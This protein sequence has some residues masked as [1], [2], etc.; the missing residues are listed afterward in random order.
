MQSA[1]KTVFAAATM[2]LF[3][4]LL[5]LPANGAVA[6]SATCYGS[7]WAL[8]VQAPTPGEVV[9]ASSLAIQVH[10]INY[11]LNARYAGTPDLPGIG[12]YHE[13]LDNYVPGMG[14]QPMPGVGAGIVDLAPTTNPTHDQ[15]SMT[16]VSNTSMP[17]A[18]PVNG[19]TNLPWPGA[20]YVTPGLHYLTLVPACNDHTPDWAAAVNIPFTYAGPYIPE[21][22]YAG[23]D[24]SPTLG[25]VSPA[26]GTGLNGTSFDMTVNV[27]NFLLCGPCYAKALESNVGHWHMFALPGQNAMPGDVMPGVFSS[28]SAMFMAMQPHMVSM[29]P[30][31]LTQQGY[32][33]GLASSPGWYTFYAVLVANNHMPF[34]VPVMMN[35]MQIG[36]MLQ[37]G[38]VAMANYY[39]SP[40]S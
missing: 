20:S 22:T 6:T 5:V 15:I 25:I 32:L 7:D 18:G 27:Q 1:K 31:A 16:A 17:A 34:T 33:I 2:A 11:Q 26:S 10:S 3:L 35:G 24:G 28:M 21:P 8:N 38:T 37:P 13:Y 29:F 19:M 39:V 40:L 9:T 14:N 23:L 12:H 4:V 30:A 36:I